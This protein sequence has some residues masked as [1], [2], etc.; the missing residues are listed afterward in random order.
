VIAA[1]EGEAWLVAG[2]AS[3]VAEALVPGMFLMW[4]GIAALGAGLATLV[5]ALGF[6]GQVIVFA[7]LAALAIGAGLRLRRA[8][9]PGRLNSAE[10]GL[11]GRSATVLA[12]QGRE[13]RVRVARATGRPG[14]PRACRC[15]K[16]ARC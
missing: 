6:A 7:V 12:F 16:R 10:S 5:A 13:G 9:R 11:V 15:P 14:W 8:H 1:H 2:L 3:L 4:L